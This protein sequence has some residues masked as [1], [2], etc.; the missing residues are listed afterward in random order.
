MLTPAIL[1]MYPYTKELN[2]LFHID[3][4]KESVR[5]SLGKY[6]FDWIQGVVYAGSEG[7]ILLAKNT[8]AGLFIQFFLFLYLFVPYPLS[9][10]SLI[11]SLSHRFIPYFASR[12]TNAM[13]A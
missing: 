9:I 6:Y 8:H 11:F 5:K 4:M 2:Y 1:Y 13:Y 3:Q 12:R 10:Y 7:K